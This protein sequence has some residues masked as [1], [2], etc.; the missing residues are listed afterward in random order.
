M[1]DDDFN[2]EDEEFD[3]DDS[4]NLEE[5][6][7]FDEDESFDFEDEF[8]RLRQKSARTSN[9]YDDLEFD[10]GLGLEERDGFFDQINPQQRLILAVLLLIDIVVIAVG[11]LAVFGVI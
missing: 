4:F 2:F 7:T 6:E 3:L 1:L 10:E 11:T 9:I 8:D 5:N